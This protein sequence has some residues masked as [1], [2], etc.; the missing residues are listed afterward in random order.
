MKWMRRLRLIN[1]HYFYDETLEFGRQTLIAGRNSAGKSTI[2]DALQVLLVANQRQ[3][4]FNSAAHDEAKRS[5]ISYLRGKTGGEE[6]KYL[7]EGDFTSYIVAEFY[8]QQKRENFVVG[9]VMDVYG[10]DTI[11]DEYFILSGVELA[12][13]DFWSPA[14]RWKN[15]EEFHRYCQNLPGRHI[16]ERSKTGYQ[17]ALLNRLGQVSERFFPVFVKA[18]SFKPIQNVRDFVYQY[19]LDEKELQL[20]LLRQN[21]EIHERYQ[22]ELEA[23]EER[24]EQL[25]AI[26]RQFD[27]F[28][29]LRD[30]V[31][32]QEYVIRGLKHTREV[33]LRDRL[34]EEI[35][36]LTAE[37]ERLGREL[38][39]ARAKQL[40]AGQKAREAYQ[41][42][43][44]HQARQR[45][46]ELKEGLARVDKDL[47]EQ[48]RLLAILR[49]TLEREKALLAGLQEME[50]DEYWQWQPGERERLGRALELLSG[51]VPAGDADWLP[52]EDTVAAV[53]DTGLF[54]AGLHSR[55]ARAVGRLEDRLALLQQQ[56]A[57]LEGQIRDLENKKRPY[58]PHVLNLKRLLEERLNRRSPVWIFC[59]E[60]DLK[61]ETWRDAVEGYLYTQRFDLLVEPRVFAEALA[62]YEREKGKHQIEGVGL[63][64]TEKEQKY[65]GTAQEG[66]LAEEMVTGNPVI[67]AHIDHLLGRVMK[68][69][70]EQDLRRYRTAITRTCMSYHNLV[71][72]Q[73]EKHRYAVP[74]IGARAIARQ[75]EIKRRELAET[76]EQIEVLKDK[77]E[78]LAA[79]LERL[80]DKKSLYAGISEQLDLPARIRRLEEERAAL[81]AEL[82]RLD[83]GEVERL[84]EEYYYWERRGQ[85]LLDEVTEISGLKKSRENELNQK[86]TELHLQETRV[87]EALAFW[88]SW[89]EQYPVELLPRA[90]ERWREAAGQELP[91][92]SKLINWENSQ[93][94]NTTRREQEFQR[95]R[96]LRH[97]YNLRYTYNADPGATDNEAYRPLLAEIATVDIPRYREK[98]AEALKQSEEEFKSHFIFKLREAIEAARRDFNELNYALKNFPFHEDRYHFEIKPSERYRR[99][100]DVIMDP[101]VMEQGSLF[102]LPEDDRTAVLHELFEKLIRGEAGELEEFT[103]YRN[104]LDFDIVVTSG[105]HRYSFSQVL[106]EKS[107]GETQTPFYVAILASFNHLYD[108]GKTV[109]LVVFDE[110]FNKMDEERIQTSLRLIKRMNLQL[111][112]AVPDEKMQ[113]MAP[114]VDT[115]LLVHRNGFHCFVD[116]I[117]RQEVLAGD[118]VPTGDGQPA[119]PGDTDGGRAGGH[120]EAGYGGTGGED[121]GDAGDDADDA[122]NDGPPLNDAASL[123][124]PA[125]G[126]DG[127]RGQ[128]GGSGGEDSGRPRRG[129]V[130]NGRDGQRLASAVPVQD[131][132]FADQ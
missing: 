24:R 107:G 90:E 34:E 131:S 110:A 86:Q 2:I 40:E 99:F 13:L 48:E 46:Q 94:G 59:E 67:Q 55:C 81:A 45:E 79:W 109:R 20:D 12:D 27:T 11:D 82:E 4:R 3:I 10:D 76:K 100:Y 98:L 88:Q 28:A 17:K 42:W 92:A 54:L 18:L 125:G 78:K 113:H 31:A 6:R 36:F 37:V 118:E 102:E 132:L 124:R 22:A 66:S 9:V 85:E 122:G 57:E 128:A 49:Q 87:Q 114:E 16:F 91:V 112:A 47:R 56:K 119:G 120:K 130:R 39:L 43:Q 64:D 73:L 14:E 61:D 80:A 93:K 60:M 25:E 105:E 101:G 7:R 58:P 5:L 52:G 96:D 103:D 21:F 1:W 26:C 65:L 106:R 111:I 53:R 63:V 104:Y 15:R 108:T 89:R 23:L 83:L 44:S 68:A 32:I 123:S 50:A 75:L 117:S 35:R 97:E 29:R 127:H 77:R 115:T 95:L 38:D 69:R 126:E 62:I 121:S 129:G 72:R 30:T 70:D 71:A 84:K 74:Y 116:M 51:L 8:D 19:I 41:K 33:E